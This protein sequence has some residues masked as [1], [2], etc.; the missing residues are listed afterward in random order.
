MPVSPPGDSVLEPVS[1][2]WER[3][4]F[5]LD[6]ARIFFLAALLI[7]PLFTLGYRTDWSSIEPTF[8]AD[9]RFLGAHWP[10]P[11]WHPNWY[12]GTRVDYVYPPLIRYGPMAVAKVLR[13]EEV[14]AYHLYIA[15]M[16]SLGIVAVY[17]LVR[18][19]SGSRRGAWLAAAATALLSPSLL[20]F[21]NYRQ[22]AVYVS[23]APVRLNVLLR[24]GEGPHISAFSLVPLVLAA[25]WLAF[26]RGSLRALAAASVFSALVVS[27]NFYGATA[28]ATYFPLMVWAV[29]VTAGDHRIFWRAALI[30]VLSYGLCALWLVPSYVWITNRNLMLVAQP[31]NRWSLWLAM[32]IVAIYGLLTWKIA[33]GR[34]ERAWMVF[35]TGAAVFFTLNVAGNYFF[36][37]RVTGEPLRHI[38]ELD[39]ALILLTVELVRKLWNW[40]SA[41]APPFPKAVAAAIVAASF[42]PAKTY[43]RHPWNFYEEDGDAVNRVEYRMQ[44]WMKRNMPESRALTTGSVRFWY[45]VWNDLPQVGGGS[46][47]GLINLN[48]M[49]ATL[50][51]AAGE[52]FDLALAWLQAMAADVVIVHD[53]TSLEAY[54]DYPNPRKFDPLG[55]AMLDDDGGNYIYRVPRRFPARA[56]IVEEK[57]IRAITEPIAATD[58][59]KVRAYADTLEKGPDTEVKLFR[60]HP[61]S[62][63]LEAKAGPG[64][65][66]AVQETFDPS[67]RASANGEELKIEPDVMG[68]MLI[69]APQGRHTIELRFKTPLEN[70]VGRLLFFLSIAAAGWLWTGIKERTARAR[71]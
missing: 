8:I 16:Y 57:A 40:S 9:A 36:G 60:R 46:E 21:E 24:Y 32:A 70:Q 63:T 37:F 64:Q 6:A 66:L 7:Y 28:L 29:W 19:G 4:E 35:V 51:A 69:R 58:F 59:A 30:A 43:L 13:I 65:I 48:T 34:A 12:C 33:R 25:S 23:F 31:G 52:S 11:K 50:E 38:P 56:R 68:F 5:R 41:W 53:K 39:L 71:V 26:R 61:D 1:P 55:P 54:H 10:P 27:H 15:V 3:R 42:L 45:N 22:D 20:F 17:L 67:W 18:I 62:M 47:Q 44:D 49:T 14:R 2:P